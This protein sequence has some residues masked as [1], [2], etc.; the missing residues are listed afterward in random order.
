PTRRHVWSSS[1]AV[2]SGRQVWPWFR[3][4]ARRRGVLAFDTG[5]QMVTANV[6]TGC[7]S[8]GGRACWLALAAAISIDDAHIDR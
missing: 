6:V 3:T 4:S 5:W 2:K 1:L 8:G 7:H